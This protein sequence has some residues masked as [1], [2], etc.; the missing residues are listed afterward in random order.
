M[1]Y[2]LICI[3]MLGGDLFWWRWAH[4][5][6]RG[7][8]RV[9]LAA[10]M[11][12]QLTYMLRMLLT[13]FAPRHNSSP[14]DVAGMS[15]AYAWHLLILPFT[16]LVMA[17]RNAALPALRQLRGRFIRL[18]EESIEADAPV[19]H[20][21]EILAAVPPLIAGAALG[22]SLAELHRFRVREM[23]V[24]LKGLP[25]SLD[26]MTIAL[27]SDTHIGRFTDDAM[28]R[29]IVETTNGFRA[30]LT[31]FAGDLIDVALADLAP[32]ID[33]A[34]RLS[35]R[36]GV[37]FCEGNHDLIEDIVKETRVFETTTRRAGLPMLFDESATVRV[38]GVPVQILGARWSRGGGI[39]AER[40]QVLMQQ[41]DPDAF[42][43][44]LSHHPHAWEE[45]T[46]PLTLSG[47]THGGQLMLNERVGVGPIMFRYWS[48]LYRRNDQALVVCNG[49]G[50]WFPLR[51]SAPA[52]IIHLTLRAMA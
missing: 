2:E 9:L 46:S 24:P 26:G 39:R 12:F 43:I 51:T 3:V 18:R 31:L 4:R 23:E 29:K 30:D 27:V 42:Q 14:L 35:G 10:F 19:L 38:R 28:L 16:L 22:I 36:Y 5:R 8:R 15:T 21:R 48:G 49:S 37:Y 11:L 52:E 45:S 6:L 34:K 25:A 41:A 32:A 47:H 7:P 1:F 40:T 50:N 20:R 13:P 17:V 44:F 33:F